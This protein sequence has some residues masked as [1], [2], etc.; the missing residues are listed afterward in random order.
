MMIA[1][2]DAA[3]VEDPSWIK[4]LITLERDG[5]TFLAR[6]P[7]GPQGRLFGGLIAAQSLAAAAATVDEEKRPQSLHAYFVS[8]GVPDVDVEL[9]VERTRDGRSFDTRR[10]T[11]LQSGAAIFEML[12]SFHRP[13]HGVDWHP[14]STP[15]LALAD[16]TASVT[17]PEIASRFELRV[18]ELGPFGFTGFPYWVRT[19]APIED[20]PIVHACTLTYLSDMGLMAAARPPDTPLNFGPGVAA[21][22]D[23]AL[24]FHRP[25]RP[26]LWHRYEAIRVDSSNACG[27]ATGAIHDEAGTQIA[28]M[29]QQALWRTEPGG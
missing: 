12:T 24:W 18:A 26:E 14:E 27:L 15:Q 6:E 28:S 10:V 2:C 11:A 23:H 5:D 1:L 16:A 3:P 13:E 25:Y 22:L 19:R 4:R 20:D 9:V 17:R 21:S 29:T 7:E 8:S